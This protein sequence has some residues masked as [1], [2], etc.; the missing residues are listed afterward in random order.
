[1]SGKRVDDF[2]FDTPE[3][4]NALRSRTVLKPNSDG[5]YVGLRISGYC[6]HCNNTEMR[7]LFHRPSTSTFA[8]ERDPERSH[9]V[10]LCVSCRR[11][12]RVELGTLSLHNESCNKCGTIALMVRA[13]SSKDYRT[14]WI[15]LGCGT[16]T[17]V[18]F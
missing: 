14:R 13:I 4:E 18:R 15:C 6:R 10:F 2:V 9:Y 7:R 12:I 17:E 8:I 3:I 16:R 1:M 5:L 11:K